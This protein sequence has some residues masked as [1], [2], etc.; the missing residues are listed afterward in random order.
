MAGYSYGHSL[1]VR[2]TDRPSRATFSHEFRRAMSEH[3]VVNSSMTPVAKCDEAHE[4]RLWATSL[5]GVVLIIFAANRFATE[6]E[7]FRSS[8]YPTGSS[9]DFPHY[10]VAAKLAGSSKPKQQQLY[11][12]MNEDKEA[13]LNV[14][15]PGSEWSHIAHQ[16]GLGDTLHFSAPPIVATLLLP[17]GKLPYQLAFMIWR[18]LTGCFYFLALWICLKLCRAF[19]PL[20]LL[21]CTLAASAFQPFTLTI[22]KGQFGA[23][24]LLTWSAAILLAQK[25]QEVLSALMLA[26]ATVIKL[27]PVLAVG[28]FVLRRKWKWVGAYVAWLLIL[29]VIGVL[30]FGVENH[31]LY[32]SKLQ[33]LS[34]GIPGPYNYSLSGIVQNTYYRDIL[35]YTHI[36]A[37]TPH[38]LCVFNKALGFAVYIGTLGVLIKKN[39]TGNI[40]WDMTVLSLITLLIAPFTWRHYYVLEI[41]PLMFVWLRLKEGKFTR[42][43][44]V[45]SIAVL[46]TL[47]AATRYPDY[48]QTHL[49]YGPARVFLVALLP[50]SALALTATLLFAYKT[51]AV[52]AG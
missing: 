23:L 6:W 37:H 41:L 16:S 44:W 43:G 32:L 24:L 26:L 47:V 51:E 40:M 7:A 35:D 1:A 22:D 45:L 20:T 36:P 39:R 42:P 33:S 34:C 19:T 49:N 13:A 18:I 9:I 21:V 52:S 10:Y 4:A 46:C 5:V 14:A 29:M 11:Y 3:L 12:L 28:V 15:P 48:L 8:A 50:L 31:R 38:R 27:T 25:K 2:Y 17:L 30:H